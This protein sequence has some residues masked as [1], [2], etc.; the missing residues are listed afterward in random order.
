VGET[1][2]I[3]VDDPLTLVSDLFAVIKFGR[4]GRLI[5]V[6]AAVAAVAGVG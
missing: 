4:D 6:T 1:G 3:G 2:K 5:G